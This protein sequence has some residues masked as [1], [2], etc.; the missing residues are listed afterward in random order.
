MRGSRE[1]DAMLRQWVDV[2]V[3]WG[4]YVV[5]MQMVVCLWHIQTRVLLCSANCRIVPATVRQ[6]EF[7]VVCSIIFRMTGLSAEL[8]AMCTH[9]GF[10]ARAVLKSNRFV[11]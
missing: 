6:V 3:G 2:G 5:V 7:R 4:V 9:W 11:R 10:C 8:D 1:A